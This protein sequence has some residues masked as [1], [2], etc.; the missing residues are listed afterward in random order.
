MM[1]AL[2][3]NVC[4]WLF[5]P[6]ALMRCVGCQGCYGKPQEDKLRKRLTEAADMVMQMQA[7]LE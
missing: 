6:E 3:P 5:H 7:L 1:H 2:V 4:S